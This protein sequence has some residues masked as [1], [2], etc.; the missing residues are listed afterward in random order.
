MA[1]D[2]Q[3]SGL[4]LRGLCR[5]VVACPRSTIP[6]AVET[7]APA[8]KSALPPANGTASPFTA[9][10]ASSPPSRG[11]NTKSEIRTPRPSSRSCR[12]LWPA[13][14]STFTRLG[15]SQIAPLARFGMPLG[16]NYRSGK[17]SP[18]Y[19]S[20]SPSLFIYYL[21]V[22]NLPGLVILM[23]FPSAR[24]VLCSNLR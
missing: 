3:G 5:A 20:L 22:V 4:R 17:H 12:L 1:Q 24:G 7:T 14:S 21:K 19:A 10:S 9:A 8:V 2:L 6:S 11:S 15:R 13:T 23:R 16:N 18:S